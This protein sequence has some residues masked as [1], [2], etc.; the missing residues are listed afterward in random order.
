MANDLHQ[1]LSETFAANEIGLLRDM[2]VQVADQRYLDM[3]NLLQAWKAHVEKLEGDL[4]LPN[5][6][7]S[8]WGAHDFIAALYMRDFLQSGLA[9]LSDNRPTH[10]DEVIAKIDARFRSFTEADALGCAERID[11]RFELARGWWWHR[12]PARGP[13]RE[14]L[15]QHCASEI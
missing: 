2:I 13:A 7:R 11:G 3:A 4:D 8:V 9:D 10:I 6:D 14:D 15:L 1:W 12:I 5:T